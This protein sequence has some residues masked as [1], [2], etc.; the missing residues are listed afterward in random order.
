MPAQGHVDPAAY[1]RTRALKTERECYVLRRLAVQA[2]SYVRLL[3]TDPAA[4]PAAKLRLLIEI[5]AYRRMQA[6]VL[7]SRLSDV[8]FPYEDLDDDEFDG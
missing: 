2:C 1:W 3:D 7:T 4:A 8:A 5:V 6:T